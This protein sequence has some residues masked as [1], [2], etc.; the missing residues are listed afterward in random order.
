MN[1]EQ[2]A[3]KKEYQ[4]SHRPMGVW[5]IRNL[6]NDKVLLGAAL[7]L[8][9]ILNRHRFELEKGSHKCQSLQNDWNTF[10]SERFSFEI[11]DE[12]SPRSDP[13]YDYRADLLQLEEMWLE[14]LQPYGE[15]GYNEPKKTREERL[16]MIMANRL[17][18]EEDRL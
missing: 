12:I 4:Q 1:A 9:G 6:V 7:N 14:N 10:G 11:L 13:A 17:G 16:Q 15:Q 18:N 8:P 2:K 3:R 5:A